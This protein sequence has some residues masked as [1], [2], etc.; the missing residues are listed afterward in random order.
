MYLLPKPQKWKTIE[1]IFTICYNRAIV[2]EN[3][4]PPE[5]YEDA[6]L[7]QQVL[8]ESLGFALRITRGSACPGDISLRLDEA[9]EAQAYELHI[10]AD[11]IIITGGSAC[12]LFMVCRHCVR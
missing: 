7:F 3:S 2:V 10:N 8:C 12:G 6:K 5:V 11:G 9:L 1:G 4:C